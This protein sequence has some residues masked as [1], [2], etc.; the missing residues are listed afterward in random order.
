MGRLYSVQPVVNQKQW[1]VGTE[2]SSSARVNY[3]ILIKYLTIICTH[4]SRVN[5]FILIK[6]LTIIILYSFF[7][8]FNSSVL[9][10]STENV[11]VAQ[12]D[13]KNRSGSQCSIC[14][15]FFAASYIKRHMSYH[16]QTGLRAS[17]L[18]NHLYSFFRRFNLRF[19]L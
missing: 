17:K 15:K 4:F 11:N 18:I 14:H 7:K 12:S 16:T 3:F 10:P 1:Q 19:T 5:Y 2:I 8:R 6:Y 9:T 13:S